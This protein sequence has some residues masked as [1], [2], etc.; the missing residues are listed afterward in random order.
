LIGVIRGR[1]SEAERERTRRHF[2][3][4]LGPGR[5]GAP[6]LR[7]LGHGQSAYGSRRPGSLVPQSTST[8][9]AARPVAFGRRAGFR[10]WPRRRRAAPVLRPVHRARQ[11]NQSI[12]DRLAREPIKVTRRRRGLSSAARESASGCKCG[13]LASVWHDH[14][15]GPAPPPPPAGLS[16]ESRAR[17]RLGTKE[18]L[19]GELSIG[20]GGGFRWWLFLLLDERWLAGA[21][22]RAGKPAAE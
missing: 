4:A 1:E 6:P 5:Q 3:P 2:L 20:R 16:R 7:A 19:G 18:L 17:A 11:T 14:R 8:T 9:A 10:R 15:K 21:D 13:P 22:G 12:M